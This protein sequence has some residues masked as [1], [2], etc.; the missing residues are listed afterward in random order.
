MKKAYDTVIV[1]GGFGGLNAAI[2]LGKKNQNVLLIDKTNHHLFQPLLYQVASA[3]LSP[4]DI[5][6]PI[7]EVLKNYPSITIVMDEVEDISKEG[8]TISLK[9][10]RIIKF[11][12][13]ILATGAR[14]SYFGNDQWEEFAPGLKS[15]DD[16]L[17]IR[18]NV[19]NS[20]EKSELESDIE[21]I[22]SLTTFVVIGAG[23]TGVEMAG[24]IAEIATKTLA[25]NFSNIDPE[26]S[27]IYL[28]EGGDRIL[29]SFH[30]SLSE[31]SKKDLES[32]G[33]KVK[34]KSFVKNITSEGVTV[35]EE[36]IPTKNIV[37]AAGN[38]ANPILLKLD[39][40]TDKMG[41]VLVE[42]DCSIEGY[43]NIY[44][45]GDACAFKRGEGFLPGLAP[46][47]AQQG[48]Y[49]A[50]LIIKKLPKGKRDSFKYVDKGAMATIGKSKAILEFG[51]IRITGFVAWVAWGL[52]H[53]LF[54]VLFRN[55][56]FIFFDWVYSYI[57]EQR[58]ARLIKN[59]K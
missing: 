5:A 23:P 36:F 50:N 17:R 16:A 49:V 39:S 53:L 27:K 48:K 40:A 35:G 19:L 29:S 41:R 52:V 57:T 3:G 28:I 9:S 4:A 12:N 6:T 46:V 2:K 51:K 45:I 33:V 22:A 10:N 18:E 8:S 1:G 30:P 13:L 7:R 54:L 47:A 24:A 14:H 20:F 56:V 25:K 21:K 58:G 55:K 42:K 32:L 31:K 26:A 59:K 34:L 44:V 43:S 11:K 15:L 38:K 37:W